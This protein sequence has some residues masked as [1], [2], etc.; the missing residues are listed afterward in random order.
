[1]GAGD[2]FAAGFIYCALAGRDARSTLEFAVA[3]SCLKHTIPG[4]CNLASRDEIER[5]ARVEAAGNAIV[6]VDQAGPLFADEIGRWMVTRGGGMGA[7][8]HYPMSGAEAKRAVVPKTITRA[9]EIGAALARARSEGRNPV[10]AAVEALSG[11]MLFQ[12][13][14]GR[15]HGEDRGG[16][17][18]TNVDLRGTGSFEGAEARLVIKNE[19]M[20]L[21]VD[22]RLRAV[23]PDLVCM[24]DPATGRGVMS[25]EVADEK[26]LVL[27]GTPC[28]PRLREGLETP[29]GR[30]AFG[31]A[32][33]GHPE[34]EYVPIERL[35]SDRAQ[36]S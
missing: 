31:G 10:E 25:V 11:T 7:N 6:V 19:T 8:N 35:L 26:E 4:D 34:V 23:F 24:L 32:R 22:G 18:V 27:V 5:L 9:L 33:Y 15:V 12:G 1:V 14:V 13:R 20:V 2:A 36:S 3:A 30:A 16:F 29:D 21:W 17:Y 28:H